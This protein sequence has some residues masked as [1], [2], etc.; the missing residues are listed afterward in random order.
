MGSTYA[1]I[2]AI[3]VPSFLAFLILAWRAPEMDD[4]GRVLTGRPEILASPSIVPLSV[5]DHP[6]T[7]RL[8]KRHAQAPVG[9]VSRQ[10]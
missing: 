10:S 1:I 2:A 4:S 5:A 3:C 9:A 6:D 8:S 7:A